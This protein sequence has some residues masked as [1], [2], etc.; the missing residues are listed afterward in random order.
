MFEVELRAASVV[1]ATKQCKSEGKAPT[2][3]GESQPR[4]EPQLRQEEEQSW[5]YHRTPQDLPRPP[6]WILLPSLHQEL[7]N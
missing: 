2:G 3:E 7:E 5:G 1:R 6:K 4:Q